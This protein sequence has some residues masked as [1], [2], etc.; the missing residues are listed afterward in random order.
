MLI[1]VSILF[2]IFSSSLFSLDRKVRALNKLLFVFIS[3][4]LVLLAGLRYEIGVDYDTYRTHYDYIPDVL[5]YYRYDASMEA[6]YE[7]VTSVFKF[8][9]APF[10]WITL[11]VASITFILLYRLSFRYSEYPIMTLLM[12]FSSMYWGQVMGQM[13]QP[14][15]ILLLYQ[16]VFLIIKN[17]KVFFLSL[18]FWLQFCFINLYF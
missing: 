10:Y 16:F 8:L 12:F 15:A 2:L 14:L 1:Y 9:N 6:G 5:H 4:F 13:R 18:L 17:K 11:F 7:F 3:I